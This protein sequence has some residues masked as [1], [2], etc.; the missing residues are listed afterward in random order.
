MSLIMPKGHPQPPASRSVGSTM[1]DL[2]NYARS[3]YGRD[4]SDQEF[5]DYG[6][7]IGFQGDSVSDTQYNQARSEID[8]QFGPAKGPQPIPGPPPSAHPTPLPPAFSYQPQFNPQI[9]AHMQRILANP[10]TMG[11]QWQDQQFEVGKESAADFRKQLGEQLSQRVAGRG[12]SGQGGI[13]Q[14]ILAGLDENLMSQLLAG[15][16]DVAM[17]AAQGNRQDLYNAINAAQGLDQQGFQNALGAYGAALQGF[18]AAEGQ[19]QFGATSDL[20][21]WLAANNV[22]LE[23]RRF[24]EGTRQ[25]DRSYGLDFLRF[26]ENQRQFGQ[27]FGE[28][29]RQFNNTLGLNWFNAQN[30][31]QNNLLNYIYQYGF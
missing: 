1:S 31:R 27:T 23:N 17:R 22:D 8:R 20:Q 4:I 13:N 6:R 16:R 11:Q 19:R 15:R 26:L 12:F 3:T 9:T 29:Q 14:A 7:R 2:R 18:Q 21:R 25:F 10:E 28:G 24:T 30:N 5:Q